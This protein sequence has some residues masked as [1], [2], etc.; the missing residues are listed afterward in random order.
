[1]EH[2]AIHAL[3]SVHITANVSGSVRNLSCTRN[4]SRDDTELCAQ[5]RLQNGA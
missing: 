1:L 4:G 3:T 2:T 5:A